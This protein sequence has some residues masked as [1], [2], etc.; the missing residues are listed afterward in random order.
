[1]R[2]EEMKALAIKKMEAIER[3]DE[4][5]KVLDYIFLI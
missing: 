2:V 1:M 5:K 4:L 3:E